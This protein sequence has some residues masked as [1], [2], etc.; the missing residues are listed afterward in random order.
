M[1]GRKNVVE[2]EFQGNVLPLEQAFKKVG[3]LF[4]SFVKEAKQ[5][6]EGGILT[7][8]QKSVEK[9]IKNIMA[10]LKPLVEKTSKGTIL[11]KEEEQEAERLYNRILKLTQQFE[12]QKN[13]IFE[14]QQRAR[15]KEQ[16]KKEREENAVD[17]TSTASQFKAGVQ[18]EQLQDFINNI[19]TLPPDVIA[20]IN[21]YIEAWKK[22]VAEFKDGKI[23]GEELAQATE[24]LDIKTREY[25][26][27]LKV[28]QHEQKTA[29]SA[30]ETLL[31][32][33]IRQISSFEFWFRK[34][35]EGIQ[36]LGDYIESLNFVEV[37]INNINYK[38]FEN[39]IDKANDALDSFTEHLNNAR[40]ALGLNATDLNQAAA[41]FI[42]FAN[43]IGMTGDTVTEFGENI[44]QLSIDMASLYNT[45]VTTMATALKSTL[46]GNTRAMMR[47]GVSVH[48]TTLNEWMLEKGLNKTMTKLNETSQAMVRYL[49]IMEKTSGAQGDL[50]RT[51]KSPA[52][53]LKVLKNQVQLLT[54]NL[55][56]I[57]NTVLYPA[58]RILNTILV[59][60]NAFLTSL[61]SLANANYSASVG[62]INESMEDLTESTN[63]AVKASKGLTN[64][65]E[66]NQPNTTGT[67]TT[68]GI[69]A[70]IQGL[71][72][73]LGVYDGF[74]E[75]TSSLTSL[76]VSLGEALAPIW[77]MLSNSVMLDALAGALDLVAKALTPIKIILDSIK[78][79]FNDSPEW[80][81]KILGVLTGVGGTLASLVT[82]I[83]MVASALAILK[84]ITMSETWGNFIRIL[85]KM[86]VGF[87]DLG[88]AIYT[89]IVKFV[90]WIATMIK[91]RI[92]AFKATVANKGLGAALLGVA[93]SALMAVANLVKL[94]A[95]LVLEGA[96][97]V[98]AAIKNLILSKSLWGIALGAI[99]AGGVAAIVVAGIVGAAVLTGK[100]V[101]GKN[102]ATES[103]IGLAS[104]GVVTGPTFALI[105][106]GKYNEA[107]V[108]LGNSPQFQS[109]KEGIAGEVI[110]RIY[111]P[112]NS[113]NNNRPIILNI[114]GKELARTILP[115]LQ[116]AVPQTGVRLSR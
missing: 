116:Q 90:T 12:R 110:N 40:W 48:D 53:Q 96:K 39:A 103:S 26:G 74:A 66:I 94:I 109:M 14:Q 32:G 36:Y 4:R 19:P 28:L 105:G 24:N 82:T 80:L 102:Q 52:N 93:K 113:S 49:Y 21:A 45:D 22:A 73:A 99:A 9:E 44:T 63:E 69:D 108:P 106:E 70:D 86:W 76:M 67:S 85:S 27:S 16:K 35:K 104:G 84:T 92:E 15:E 6:N 60:L 101:Q 57:F 30:M 56:A 91:A 38:G 61:T 55:G 88:K 71:V 37:A 81:Q 112:S 34:I 77:E 58:I 62:N 29:G 18:A 111:S 100:A 59:P 115:D 2:Y 51:L 8:N 43:A 107:V 79:G 10:R 75:K 33:I 47:F 87:L 68:I 65:D 5:G 98:F 11:T 95:K 20:D 64:L 1:A 78:A 7:P 41:T 3:S 13:K 54:Q 42:S 31:N 114:N 25:V 89:A 23:S 46:A 50:S 72:N 97:A 83:M 17:Y